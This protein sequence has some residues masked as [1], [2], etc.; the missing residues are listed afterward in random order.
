MFCSHL[1]LLSVVV[2]VLLASCQSS[3]GE[4]TAG[5][6]QGMQ[7]ILVYQT[8]YDAVQFQCDPLDA[9]SRFNPRCNLDPSGCDDWQ[10]SGSASLTYCDSEFFVPGRTSDFYQLFN[11]TNGNTASCDSAC[12]CITG[13]FT[14]SGST[15][16]FVPDGGNC[17]VVDSQG[18]SLAPYPTA[19]PSASMPPTTL[20]V[21][22]TTVGTMAPATSEPT[23]DT[24]EA[25]TTSSSGAFSIRPF[26]VMMIPYSCI[27][28]ATIFDCLA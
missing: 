23:E 19:S 25:P 26:V 12:T 10:C 9:T 27:S 11:C 14:G 1:F 22:L 8:T 15:L 16:V 2:A 3:Q 7:E 6:Q 28:A 5:R 20:A 4:T 17:T 18:G 13:N 21:Q 24:S